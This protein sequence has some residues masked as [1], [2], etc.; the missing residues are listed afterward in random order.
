MHI[1]QSDTK[2]LQQINRINMS[3]YKR[4]E[5]RDQMWKAAAF[6]DCVVAVVETLRTSAAD[7][8]PARPAEEEWL[9]SSTNLGELERRMRSLERASGGPAFQTFNH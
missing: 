8:N 3:E 5:A 7:A 2:L 4:A 1:T 9:A 6:V